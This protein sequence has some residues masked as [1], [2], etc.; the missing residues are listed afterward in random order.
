MRGELP[1]PG[2]TKR[3]REGYTAMVERVSKLEAEAAAGQR[4]ERRIAPRI[5]VLSDNQ[6]TPATTRTEAESGTYH[7]RYYRHGI[8]A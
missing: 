8:S 4:D 2:P 7:V 5:V 6:D 3:G 1:H